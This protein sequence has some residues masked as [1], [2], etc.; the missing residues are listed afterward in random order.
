MIAKILFVVITFAAIGIVALV[1]VQQSKGDTGS[2]FGG[3]GGSQSL[4]GSRGSANFL[5][6]LTSILVAVFFLSSIGLAYH[7]T[8]QNNYGS[9]EAT[10]QES[11]VLDSLESLESEVPSVPESAIP[12]D[13]T[14]TDIPE[15]EALDSANSAVPAV[16][17]AENI[18]S[19]D[20]S[21]PSVPQAQTSEEDETAIPAVPE[22]N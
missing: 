8:E 3:G 2:A 22:S 7:Y 14:Q 9:Y 16:T 6:R 18:K 13:S 12:N 17:E 21:V 20:N 11:S 4:F 1:L 5:S 15:V 19:Q 10:Q